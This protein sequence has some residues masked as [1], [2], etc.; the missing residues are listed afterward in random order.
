[1]AEGALANSRGHIA[2]SIT[3]FAGKGAEGEEPGL[4]HFATAARNGAI[5][6]VERRFGDVGRAEVR[7]RCLTTALEL[8]RERMSGTNGG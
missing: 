3:G 1:M 4:V 2:V 8:I 7:L 6:H 5:L